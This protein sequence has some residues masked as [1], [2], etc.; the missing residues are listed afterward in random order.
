MTIREDVGMSNPQGGLLHATLRSDPYAEHI[1][2]R[3]RDF[4]ADTTPWQR[5]L[6][7]T[8]TVLALHELS[9]ASDWCA[10]GV[11]TA[12]AVS[13]LARDIERLAGKDL[14]V[15]NRDLR[16]Q[17][18][19]TLRSNVPSGSRHHRR[20]R[21]LIDF[22]NGDYLV[23]WS[24]AVGGLKPPSPERCSRA[25]ASHLLDCGYSMRFLRR[26]IARLIAG[27]ESLANLFVSA[28]DLANGVSRAYQVV[29]PFISLPQRE[30]LATS[31]PNWQSS[32]EIREWLQT[33][34]K[35]PSGYRQNGGFGYTVEARDAFAAADVA[36]AT[37]DRLKARSS[38]GRGVGRRGPVPVG[39]V[40]VVGDDQWHQVKLA[41]EP[42]SSY[43]LSLEAERRLYDVTQ[44]TSID[45]ALELAAP[46]K[47]S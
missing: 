14:G 26:W 42:R 7:D 18:T 21:E 41:M 23:G 22:V 2:A 47:W 35:Y 4:F 15:G 29:V 33:S 27:N 40:W 38:H 17:L 6:W 44:P 19:E 32:A 10:K 43:V 30:P 39:D 31:L 24:E 37:V 12:G 20:L 34:A 5:R 8:G 3:L 13:W 45:D 16:V 25:I 11:L 1:G 36:A 46:L 9:E 28:Q